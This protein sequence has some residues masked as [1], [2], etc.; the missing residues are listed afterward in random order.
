MTHHQELPLT[1]VMEL[2]PDQVRNH[3]EI[4]VELRPN[5]TNIMFHQLI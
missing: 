4:I 5:H 1:W 2:R 3:H